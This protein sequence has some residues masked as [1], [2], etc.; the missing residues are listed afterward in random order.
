M[1]FLKYFLKNIHINNIKMLYYDRIDVCEGI[2]VNKTS[3]QKS[4]LFFTF[5]IF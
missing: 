2:E 3:V 5:G 4:A 1:I